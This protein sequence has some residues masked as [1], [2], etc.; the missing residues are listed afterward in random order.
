[1]D[2][3]EVALIEYEKA[4]HDRFTLEVVWATIPSVRYFHDER[5][6]RLYTLSE[7]PQV[8]L[9]KGKNDAVGIW[10]I[11]V[12]LDVLRA[13]NYTIGHRWAHDIRE[14]IKEE[15]GEYR[16]SREEALKYFM[17]TVSGVGREISYDE[18]RVIEAIYKKE[19]KDRDA[20]RKAKSK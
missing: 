14:K 11:S 20:Q 12:T 17:S 2:E 1:M 7:P 3:H 4:R 5:Y 6:K 9:K 15:Y 18:Y 8:L 16:D 10:K 13:D 19:I